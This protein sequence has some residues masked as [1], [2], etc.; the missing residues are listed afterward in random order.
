MGRPVLGTLSGA[1]LPARQ[2]VLPWGK[3]EDL[4]PRRSLMLAR[5]SVMA[6]MN[7]SDEYR[8]AANAVLS[9]IAEGVVVSLGTPYRLSDAAR[10]HSDLEAGRTSGSLYLVP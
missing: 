3:V 7:G 10:A 9:L 8:T 6:Y 5:P 1:L 2:E 4:G